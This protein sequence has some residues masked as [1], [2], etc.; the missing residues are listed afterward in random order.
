MP[1]QSRA[2]AGFEVAHEERNA[3]TILLAFKLDSS[4]WS[5]P[6]IAA[7]QNVEHWSSS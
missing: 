7:T 3:G 6:L 5:L 2:F 4:D 1:V